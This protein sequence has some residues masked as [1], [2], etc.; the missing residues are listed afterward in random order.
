MKENFYYFGIFNTRVC[1]ADKKKQEF[2]YQ[3]KKLIQECVTFVLGSII[4]LLNT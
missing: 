1:D 2:V 4:T 3:K